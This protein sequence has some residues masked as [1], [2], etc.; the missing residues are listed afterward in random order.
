MADQN[1]NPYP[2]QHQQ[3]MPHAHA[4]PVH[5]EYSALAGYSAGACHPVA[6]PDPRQAAHMVTLHKLAAQEQLL[7]Q[8]REEKKQQDELLRHQKQQL[9]A[10]QDEYYSSVKILLQQQQQQLQ[11]RPPQPQHPQQPQQPQP[12]QHQPHQ[13][14]PHPHPQQ[15]PSHYQHAH[16]QAQ[17]GRQQFQPQPPMPQQRFGYQPGFGHAALEQQ[18]SS[19]RSKLGASQRS[20]QFGRAHAAFAAAE[21]AVVAA[22]A[23]TAASTS[24]KEAYAAA[25]FAGKVSRALSSASSYR[26]AANADQ[27]STMIRTSSLHDMSG[28]GGAS[29]FRKSCSVD[30]I[31]SL[32]GKRSHDGSS[33]SGRRTPPSSPPRFAAAADAMRQEGLRLSEVPVSQ[34]AISK[35]CQEQLSSLWSSQSGRTAQQPAEQ[36]ARPHVGGAESQ[37]VGSERELTAIQMLSMFGGV[38]KGVSMQAPD[39]DLKRR[40]IFGSQ[41]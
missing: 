31:S 17:Q 28:T 22:A 41:N 1:A 5:P 10:Q 30:S 13:P 3:Y 11:Q 14:H 29:G 7:N 32:L 8:Y 23:S 27:E 38:A 34:M 24:V 36:A 26:S 2:P 19:L 33:A 15:L 37:S 12:Q 4:L 25:D 6:L 35:K 21:S 16:H 20:E 40:R 39:A 9:A 18:R